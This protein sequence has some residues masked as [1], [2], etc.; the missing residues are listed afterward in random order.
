MVHCSGGGAV[1]NT[2]CG[3]I[4]TGHK[5]I[6][7]LNLNTSNSNKPFNMNAKIK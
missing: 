1:R 5:V 6:W 3:K 2:C 7:K 4:L